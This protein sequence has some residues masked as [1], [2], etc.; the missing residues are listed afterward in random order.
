MWN[1]QSKNKPQDLVDSPEWLKTECIYLCRSIFEFVPPSDLIKAYQQAHQSVLQNYK[2]NDPLL[3]NFKNF[4]SKAVQSHYDMEAIEYSLRLNDK[5]N[6]LTKKIN[7]LLYI[8]ETQPSSYSIFVNEE[9]CVLKAYALLFF[10]TLR[11]FY[12]LAKGMILL[13]IIIPMKFRNKTIS[14]QNG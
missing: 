14:L 3:H 4:V 12:K 5:S 11:S 8:I 13:K 2:K 7:V 10:Q 1:V 6:F 9:D